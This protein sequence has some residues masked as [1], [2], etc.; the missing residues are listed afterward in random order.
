MK[1]TSVSK[2]SGILAGGNWIVDQV[3]IIDTYPQPEQ[4]ANITSQHQGTG[5]APY[6]VLLDLAKL[7]AEFPLS[8]AGMV[9]KDAYGEQILA[10]C[11][12]YKIDTRLLKTTADAPTSFT[13]VMTVA[14]KGQRTFF[15]CRGANALWEAKDLDFSKIKARIFHLGYL[16][17]LD[18]LDVVNDCGSIVC[19]A[20]CQPRA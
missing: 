19:M 9:G 5:G 11:A 20:S 2:R 16:L 18:K 17:L 1:A 3:K 14:G 4:L 10:D 7:G 8:G 15:H 6:N 12:R 13:D